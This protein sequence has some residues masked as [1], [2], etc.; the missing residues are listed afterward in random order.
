[1][2][3]D[4]IE[5]RFKGRAFRYVKGAWVLPGVDRIPVVSDY[6]VLD[7]RRKVGSGVGGA[8]VG[9]VLL[10][11]I[12]LAAGLLGARRKRLGVIEWDDGTQSLVDVTASHLHRTLIRAAF[13]SRRAAEGRSAAVGVE[14]VAQEGEDLGLTRPGG[15]YD[16]QQLF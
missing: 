5:G 2:A 9:V 4:V 10:G 11:P 15:A 3:N 14:H 16:E 12:G 7:E 6:E 1:M 8:A 13:D